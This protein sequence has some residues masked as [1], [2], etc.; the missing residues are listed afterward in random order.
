MGQPIPRQRQAGEC[1]QSWKGA[2][3]AP[4]R[5]P[6]PNSKQTSLLTKTSF[7]GRLTS[8]RRVAAGDQLPRRDTPRKFSSSDGGGDKSQPSAG[9]NYARQGPGHLSCS[10]LGWCKTQAQPSLHLCGVS[11]NLNLR[12]LDLGSAVKPGPTSDSSWQSNLESEQCRLGKDT[13]CEQGQTQC[14]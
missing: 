6:I 1:S 4:E 13:C 8:A 12:A 2:I 11:E 3:A 7:S 5:H 10:D 9:G 14:G